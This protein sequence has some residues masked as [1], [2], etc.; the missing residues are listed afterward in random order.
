MVST[1]GIIQVEGGITSVPKSFHDMSFKFFRTFF[2]TKTQYYKSH[3]D[4][5]F[6][7]DC[8]TVFSSTLIVNQIVFVLF[9]K[10]KTYFIRELILLMVCP[11]SNLS[12]PLNRSTEDSFT[13]GQPQLQVNIIIF[14][15]H[16]FQLEED[17]GTTVS[18]F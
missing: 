2:A 15:F 5:A 4:K 14:Y 17:L 7:T 3:G 9:N 1:L 8:G 13:Q 18:I 6:C 11:V 16:K 12:W 10:K